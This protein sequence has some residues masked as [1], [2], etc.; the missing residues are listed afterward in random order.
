MPDL[1]PP[2][3]PNERTVG[4]LVAESIR[5]YG[6]T[7]L[8]ALPLGVPYTLVDQFAVHR[9][10]GEQM[11]VFWIASP[12]IAGAFVYA[13]A[14]V[15]ERRPT[16]TVFALALLIYLP[17]PAL[18][19]LYLLPGVAWFAFIGLA[20]PAALVEQLSWRPALVRGREL[21]SADF[22]HAFG[23]LAALVI[24][25]GVG[26]ETL[27]LLLRTQGDSSQRIA[28]GLAD[29]VLS[30][31]LYLGGALLYLDQ[32]ARVGS[33]RSKHRRTKQGRRDADFHPSVDADA[34]GRSDAQVEP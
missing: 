22:V 20:V 18:R 26:S 14:L 33:P 19:A 16:A 30:P 2:L 31:L 6:R 34:A 8:T 12:L 28:L 21:G 25:V 32:A 13:C 10:A 3:P 24:V 17:F 4:Q 11:L 5:L 7:F 9:T 29:L 27:S 1:P 15:H 23:S